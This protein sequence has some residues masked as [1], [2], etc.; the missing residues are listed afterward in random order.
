M[1][2]GLG[3]LLLAS[4]AAAGPAPAATTHVH[5][6][7]F[8]FGPQVIDVSVGDTVTWDN[9]DFATHTVTAVDGSFNSGNLGNG[10]TFQRTFTAAATVAYRCNIHGSMTG[11]IRVSLPGG[12]PDLGVPSLALPQ[13][14]PTTLPGVQQ[15]IDLT[16]RN[17]GTAT[18]TASSLRV[19]YLYHGTLRTI[20]TFSVP[21]LGP[22]ES[23]AFSATWDTKL[24]VGDF[25]VAGIADSGG[26][27][28]ESN[29]SNNIREQTATILLP[30]A[31]VP[32]VDLLE[33]V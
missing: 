14:A 24:K 25:L 9:H 20:A 8:A 22:G 11:K 23:A 17:E 31:G 15:R 16:T 32:G 21:I 27:I 6:S 12:L 18:A 19:A 30:V 29:E 13:N 1:A 33:P 3:A 26:V 2:L 7:G 5:I 28:A 4:F 10:G